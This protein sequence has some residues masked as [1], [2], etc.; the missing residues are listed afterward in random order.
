MSSSLIVLAVAS[1]E[2]RSQNDCTW[3]DRGCKLSEAKPA[4]AGRPYRRIAA[5][6]GAEAGKARPTALIIALL[7]PES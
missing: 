7:N 1:G 2:S 6:S 5:A 3:K 4:V